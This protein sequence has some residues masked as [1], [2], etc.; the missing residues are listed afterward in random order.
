MAWHFDYRPS[1][2]EGDDYSEGSSVPMVSRWLRPGNRTYLE[3]SSIVVTWWIVAFL[4]QCN[5]S[6]NGIIS[7]EHLPFHWTFRNCNN[8]MSSGY[9]CSIVILSLPLLS[10]AAVM[11][12]INVHAPLPAWSAVTRLVRTTSPMSQS[13]L[14]A[15]GRE[16]LQGILLLKTATIH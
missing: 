11:C 13:W 6:C 7:S 4:V 3:V 10:S 5:E 8:N 9:S 15:A 1:T 14:M 16:Q 2:S 12:M